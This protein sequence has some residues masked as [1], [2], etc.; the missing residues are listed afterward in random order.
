[1]EPAVHL[2]CAVEVVLAVEDR[3]I[4]VVAIAKQHLQ[5][6]IASD[7]DRL[8]AGLGKVLSNGLELGARQRDGDG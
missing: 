7:E 4:Y 6:E 5:F 1:V 3:N 8:V 2:E